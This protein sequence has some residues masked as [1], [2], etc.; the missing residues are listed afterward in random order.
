MMTTLRKKTDKRFTSVTILRA[1]GLSWTSCPWLPTTE[2]PVKPIPPFPSFLACDTPWNTRN[3]V[4]GSESLQRVLFRI[5]QRPFASVPG[6]QRSY[7]AP[8]ARVRILGTTQYSSQSTL[9]HHPGPPGTQS[10]TSRSNN[11][12]DSYSGQVQRPG[13]RPEQTCPCLQWRKTTS[14]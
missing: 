9:L 4:A 14:R 5:T 6:S 13:L 11:K 12:L 8:A 3:R 1:F 7:P 2:I 10:A